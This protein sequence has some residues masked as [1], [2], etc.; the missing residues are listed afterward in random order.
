MI[1]N[2]IKIM[3]FILQKVSNSSRHGMLAI[4]MPKSLDFND[5]THEAIDKTYEYETPICLQV[6][7]FRHYK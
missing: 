1:F 4:T 3:D 5:D 6:T 7:T 2:A